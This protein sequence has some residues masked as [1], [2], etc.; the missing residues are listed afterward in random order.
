MAN[1]PGDHTASEIFEEGLL[2]EALEELDTLDK[3]YNKVLGDAGGCG[4]F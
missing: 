1:S 3:K 4:R 2:P